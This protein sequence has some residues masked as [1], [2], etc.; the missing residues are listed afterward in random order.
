VRNTES[1]SYMEEDDLQALELPYLGGRFE[2]VVLLPSATDGLE[3]LERKISPE[4]I[5]RWG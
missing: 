1:F 5:E 3:D 4:Q 2:M